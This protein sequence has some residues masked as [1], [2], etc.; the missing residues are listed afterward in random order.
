MSPISKYLAVDMG[1][2][3]Q[4]GR[5]RPAR[6]WS[7]R[8]QDET[9]HVRLAEGIQPLELE[10]LIELLAD[11][12]ARGSVRSIVFDAAVTSNPVVDA[13]LDALAGAIRG[14]GV[15]VEVPRP[16]VDPKPA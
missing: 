11:L 3:P 9:L 2:A 16:D 10:S 8:T 13:F 14:W 4:P 5:G 7:L 12:T 15:Q 6:S 1:S